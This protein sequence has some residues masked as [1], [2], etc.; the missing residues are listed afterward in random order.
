MKKLWGILCLLA[1]LLAS[2][3]YAEWTDR[4]TPPHVA[5]LSDILKN[6]QAWQDIPVRIPVRFNHVGNIYT[7]FFTQFN[8]EQYINFSAW[9]VQTHVWDKEGFANDYAYFYIEKDVPELKSFLKLKTFDT[10][11]VL[12]KV[13]GIFRQKPAIRITWFCRIPGTLDM[14]NLRLMYKGM[15]AFRSRKFDEAVTTFRK[16][17]PT[18]PPQDVQTM[19]HKLIAKIYIYEKKNYGQALEEL[20]KALEI[21]PKDDETVELHQKCSYYLQVGG[22]PLVPAYWEEDLEKQKQ[23]TPPPQQQPKTEVKAPA[24]TITV[25]PPQVTTPQ[26]T[27]TPTPVPVPVTPSKEDQ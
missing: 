15:S 19:L 9:D 14:D 13:S 22:T 5:Y 27:P 6:P 18:N 24:P 17:L 23:Q 2:P 20:N 11:S 16:V 4:F 1:V 10:I 7:P 26:V 8:S 12:A 25:E 21:N 3:V